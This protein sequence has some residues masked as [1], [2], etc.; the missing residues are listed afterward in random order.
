MPCGEVVS[1][2]SCIAMPPYESIAVANG[3]IELAREAGKPVTVM[4]LLK[5]VYFAHGWHLALTDAELINE[6]V[7]AWKF[8]PVV[9]SVYHEFKESGSGPIQQ[10]G[11][12]LDAEAFETSNTIRWAP[13]RLPNDAKLAA[14][15]RRIWDV[16]G[17]MSGYQLSNLTHQPGTPWDKAWNQM[18]GSRLK[19][20]NIPPDNIRDYFKSRLAPA[21]AKIPG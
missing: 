20:T 13:P 5:L 8:G 1:E 2:L 18:G 12:V 17:S 16:Y 7:Q 15:M 4:Q 3:F 21:H 9:P 11:T 14:F 19:G 6:Q 10:L